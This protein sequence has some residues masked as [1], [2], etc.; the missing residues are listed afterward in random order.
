MR[1]AIIFDL[2]GTILDTETPE[3]VSWQEVYS[4]HGVPLDQAVWAQAIGTTDSGFD[5]YRHLET[6]IG[7]PIDRPSI[8]AARHAHFDRLMAAAE[9]RAGVV[10]WLDEARDL[11]VRIG[12]ASSSGIVWVSRFLDALGLR[13]RFE[14]LATRNRVEHSK[15]APDLYE[16]AVAELGVQPGEAV[17][18]E[19]SPNGVLAAKS[20]GLYCVAVPNPMTAGLALDGADVRLTSLADHPLRDFLNA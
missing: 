9:P 8:R 12:L 15:P 2:D 7:N 5:P 19:D 6:L 1:K 13:D 16:L 20:A 4:A 14:V 11:G 18:V 10:A 3:F 17:A